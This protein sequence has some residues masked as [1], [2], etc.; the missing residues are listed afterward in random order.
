VS[1]GYRAR[2]LC[3]QPCLRRIVEDAFCSSWSLV[4]MGCHYAMRPRGL[5]GAL[6]SGRS[7]LRQVVD[8]GSLVRSPALVAG[9]YA[10]GMSVSPLRPSVSC[11]CDV[12]IRPVWTL[13]SFFVIR[14]CGRFWLVCG[15]RLMVHGLRASHRR[16]ARE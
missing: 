8:G 16:R 11:S 4:V 10:R 7:P 12:R 6:N 3:V 2:R 1:A 13:S 9:T 14:C 5:L 15:G